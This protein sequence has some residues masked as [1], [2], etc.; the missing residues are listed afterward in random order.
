[1]LNDQ[2]NS[3]EEPL[4]LGLGKCFLHM[5]VKTRS[6]KENINKLCYNK[7][8]NFLYSNKNP[9]KMMNRQ[10]KTERKYLQ[11][12]H[13]TEDLYIDMQK[14]VNL[15]LSSDCRELKTYVHTNTNTQVGCCFIC[16]NNNNKNT[17][18][19]SGVCQWVNKQTLL[20]MYNQVLLT[21][22]KKHKY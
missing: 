18:D 20:C 17:E 5:I 12:M 4:G 1:M 13:Q 6:F 19:H 15:Q 22:K 11:T 16:N 14:K 9:V 21:N 8:V 2:K 3:E 10:A 7:I